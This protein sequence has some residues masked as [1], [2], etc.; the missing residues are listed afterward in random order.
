MRG[1]ATGGAVNKMEGT[2][3]EE[4]SCAEEDEAGS[5][6]DRSGDEGASRESDGDG[7]EGALREGEGDDGRE[8]LG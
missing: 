3:C 7:E 1:P 8:T 6:A 5:E 4:G 2:V